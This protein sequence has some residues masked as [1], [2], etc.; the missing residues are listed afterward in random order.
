MLTTLYPK[1]IKEI[2]YV[3]HSRERVCGK[4]KYHSEIF[5]CKTAYKLYKRK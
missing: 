4:V 2:L 1:G 3:S 5:L